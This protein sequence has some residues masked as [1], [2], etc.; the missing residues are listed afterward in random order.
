MILI[1]GPQDVCSGRD[2]NSEI[3]CKLRSNNLHKIPNLDYDYW[4]RFKLHG[5]L[6]KSWSFGF[7]WMS[8]N[9][10]AGTLATSRQ[11]VLTACSARSWCCRTWTSSTRARKQA[12]RLSARM[13]G[14]SMAA[15]S[16]P[17]P[18]ALHLKHHHMQLRSGS[19]FGEHQSADLFRAICPDS[20]GYL[21]RFCNW[22][23]VAGGFCPGW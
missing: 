6:C 3:L 14:S 18:W 21:S 4:S 17:V 8:V 23:K 7:Y 20:K 1:F 15:T 22:D 5:V 11:C 9:N 12:G 13:P 16:L 10:L 19:R 2:L